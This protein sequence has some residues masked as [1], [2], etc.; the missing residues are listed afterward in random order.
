MNF[1]NGTPSVRIWVVGTHRILGV[2]E[3]K[4]VDPSYCNLPDDILAKLSW[5][6]DLFGDFMVCPFTKDEPGVMRLVCVQSVANASI[7]G[8]GLK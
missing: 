2:S 7:R 3:S 5:N 1:S 8:P 4:F 6:N